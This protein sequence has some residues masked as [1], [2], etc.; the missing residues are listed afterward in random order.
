MKKISGKRE[1]W[2][3]RRQR[4]DVLS[5]RRCAGLKKS[6][7]FRTGERL[8]RTSPIAVIRVPARLVAETENDR[9]AILS[10]VDDALDFLRCGRRV[11]FDFTHTLKAFPGGLLV[12]LAYIELMVE[13]FPSKVTASVPHGSLISQLLQHFGFAEKLGCSA[14]AATHESVIH[15]R[16]LTGTQA[17]GVK[18]SELLA[19]YKAVSAIVIPEGLYDVLAEALTNVRHH[20]YPASESETPE[21][22]RKWWLFSR[23]EIPT[24]DKP[25]R[26]FLA[27]YDIGVGIQ[28]SLRA[29]LNAGEIVLDKAD[30]LLKLLNLGD[31]LNIERLLLKR[32][33]EE[34]RSQTGLSFRGNG[35]PEM[36]EFVMGTTSGRM[37]IV[38]GS[39]QYTC[40]AADGL[41]EAFGCKVALP[42]TLILWSIPL[43]ATTK[44]DTK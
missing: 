9:S 32:A 24:K 2:L 3:S 31:N 15:W 18:I 23:Y 13:I 36:K 39:G 34:E 11:K 41:S 21:S 35:L 26:L 12:L 29:K 22:L 6:H 5:S 42:G 1:E 4:V 44:D 27:V 43:D 33:V 37:Y 28:Q 17:D 40:N 25:G 20:A 14:G 7:N 30:G 38:S 10:C 16:F 8:G 19:T